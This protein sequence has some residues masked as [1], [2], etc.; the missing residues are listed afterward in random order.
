MT[1]HDTSSS[2]YP[3]TRARTL[4][5]PMGDDASSSVMRHAAGVR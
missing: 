1:D 2:F 3:Y 5:A 4:N